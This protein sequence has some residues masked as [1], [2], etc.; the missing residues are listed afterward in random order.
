MKRTNLAI[1]LVLLI[2]GSVSLLAFQTWIATRQGPS[3]PTH[4]VELFPG[5]TDLYAKA[6]QEGGL[7]IYTVW[8]TGDMAAIVAAFSKQYPDLKA[9]YWAARNPDIIAR[10]LNEFQA[11]QRTV[12]IIL[13]DSS[14]PVIK[15][16][17]ATSPYQTVQKDFLLIN[18]PT[19]PVVGL[20]I[21]VLA[22]NTKLL[23]QNDLPKTWEDVTRTQYAGKVALDDPLRAGPLSQMLA[24][25]Y[26]YWKNETRW[27]NFLR[28]LRALNATTYQS[29]SEMFNLLAAGEYT[30]AMP[31]LLHDVLNEKRKGGPVDFV[32]TAPPVVAPR[33]AAIYAYAPHPNAAKLFAEWLISEDGQK[34]LDSIGRET[35]RKG[36]KG[37]ASVEASFPEGTEVISLRNQ[38]YL[39]NPKAWLTEHV[40][41]IWEGG[42][43]GSPALFLGSDLIAPEEERSFLA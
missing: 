11:H 19:M 35:V 33:F 28:G 23:P 30:I 42:S 3:Q 29:T 20:Q 36:F 34:A 13:A 38:E 7:T 9:D 39:A 5:E 17:G 40:K 25:L 32:R 41:P 15:A 43:Q 26:T 21:Q 10:V 24:A 16:A 27:A 31:S 22:Y 14:P 18:D 8:E 6:R 12:D 37:V 2:A 4:L 1:I